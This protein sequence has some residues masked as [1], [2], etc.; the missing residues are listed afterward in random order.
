M[1]EI[2]GDRAELGRLGRELRAQ[3]VELAEELPP[4]GDL[5]LLRSGEPE[6]VDRHEPPLHGCSTVVRGTRPEE[7]PAAHLILRAAGLLRA[8]GWD[9]AV[10]EAR[11]EGTEDEETEREY[12]LIARRPDGSR[13]EVRTNDRTSAVLYSGW[14]PAQDL[15]E[16]EEFRWPEPVRT[17]RTLTSGHLLCYECDGLG[18]CDCCGGRGWLP[19]EPH[20]RERCPQC[21]TRRVCPICRGAGE[22]AVSRLSPY[23]RGHYP[24]LGE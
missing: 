11:R 14:A 8:A 22:L 23:E 9:V 6:L 5:D 7:V 13:V 21:F 10:P 17:P 16:P 12:V 15:R 1:G 18:A 24:E 4:G 19:A 3:L 20:G 2:P